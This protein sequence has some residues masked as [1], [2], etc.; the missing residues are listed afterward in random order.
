MK[1]TT[2]DFDIIMH[3]CI[4]IY[5]DS[6]MTADEYLNRYDFLGHMAADLTIYQ[7]L[8]NF[9]MNF[10]PEQITFIYSHSDIVPLLEEVNTSIDLYNI[11]FHHD[12]GYEDNQ[13]KIPL[14]EYNEGNWVKKLWDDKKIQS[15]VWIKDYKSE[16]PSTEVEKKYLTS[17]HFI[18]SYDLDTILDSDKIYISL[19]SAWIPSYYTPLYDL[20]QDLTK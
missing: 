17:K 1:I 12:I 11:D 5:N 10:K 8:T 6:D 19:S 15:Y 9:I 16:N 18:Q 2:I 14:R 7:R 3:P 20:W 4:G 13:W